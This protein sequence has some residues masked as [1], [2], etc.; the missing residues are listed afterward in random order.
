MTLVHDLG[1]CDPLGALCDGVERDACGNKRGF[2]LLR[3]SER[4]GGY[5]TSLV[6]TYRSGSE[7][8][9]SSVRSS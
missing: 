9:I 6:V 5:Y 1:V 7:K 4:A 8:E 2:G 3:E